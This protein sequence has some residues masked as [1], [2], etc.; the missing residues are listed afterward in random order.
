MIL[1]HSSLV[2][3]AGN[4]IL[5]F[6]NYSESYPNCG[7]LTRST[8]TDSITTK[9]YKESVG[10]HLKNWIKSISKIRSIPER[11]KEN[12]FLRKTVLLFEMKNKRLGV[13][14]EGVQYIANRDCSKKKHIGPTWRKTSIFSNAQFDDGFLYGIEDSNGDLTGTPFFIKM[15]TIILVLTFN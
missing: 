6:V 7:T 12:F 11:E 5:N 10:E 1:I 2:V 9:W 3:I 8:C 14:A 15:H 13:M 4:L